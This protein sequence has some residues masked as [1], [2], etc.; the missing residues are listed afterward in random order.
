MIDKTIKL[1]GEYPSDFK[2]DMIVEDIQQYFE[3]HSLYVARMIGGS[4]TGYC[5]E[6]SDDLIV[7]NANVLMPGYGKVWY[8]D[9]N[10]TE[11]YLVLREISE[12]LNTTLYV[13][14]ESDGRFGEENKPID[15][16][17]KKSVWNTDEPNPTREWYKNKMDKKYNG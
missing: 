7:F 1:T 6:H 10:L 15:E 4:K 13:L 5:T 11:D 12:C 3:S 9:L 16:L 8:G 17:V 14:W 2:P